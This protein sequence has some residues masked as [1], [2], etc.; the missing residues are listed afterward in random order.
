M[1]RSIP[2]PSFYQLTPKEFNTLLEL[3]TKCESTLMKLSGS[4]DS[5]EEVAGSKSPSEKVLILSDFKEFGTFDKENCPK[6]IDY[7][8]MV[9]NQLTGDGFDAC[10]K[11]IDKASIL[12]AYYRKGFTERSIFALSYYAVDLGLSVFYLSNQ[13][14]LSPAFSPEWFRKFFPIDPEKYFDS[15]SE[16]EM[17]NQVQL[18]IKNF[19]KPKN[20]KGINYIVLIISKV[21]K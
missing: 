1:L 3:C 4:A 9:P 7:K 17:W 13:I 10:R 21:L 11:A 2:L 20:Q 19:N 15:T 14:L 18:G 8:Q 6:R 16:K 5:L 12:V